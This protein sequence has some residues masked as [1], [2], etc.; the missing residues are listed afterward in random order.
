MALITVLFGVLLVVSL[1]IYA[2]VPTNKKTVTIRK[3]AG[4]VHSIAF[5]IAI[6]WLLYSFGYNLLL[7]VFC[8]LFLALFAIYFFVP[9]KKK[10]VHKVANIVYSALI[11][12]PAL[13]AVVYLIFFR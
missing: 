8:F 3:V 5:P 2:L 11:V 10:A 1:L 6:L 12:L 7:F 9:R 4:T 13:Y